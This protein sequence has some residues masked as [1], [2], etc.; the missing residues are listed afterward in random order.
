[1]YIDFIIGIIIYIIV[2]PIK[3]YK[4]LTKTE[5]EASRGAAALNVNAT[6]CEFDFQSSIK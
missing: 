2:I 1:M 4:E 5:I 6:G 3:L